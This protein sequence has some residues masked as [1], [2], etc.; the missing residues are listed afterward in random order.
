MNDRRHA[1]ARQDH[2][3]GKASKVDTNRPPGEAAG[4]VP[5]DPL[6]DGLA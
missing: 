6:A 1:L 5:A 4:S 2:G 3:K